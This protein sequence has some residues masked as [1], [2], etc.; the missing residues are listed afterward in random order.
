MK[1]KV[2]NVQVTAEVQVTLRIKVPDTWGGD[3]P[4]EQVFRQARDSAVSILNR[5]LQSE[6]DQH[7]ISIV[8]TPE[9]KTIIGVRK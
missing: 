1:E 2:S 4:T 8:A 7:R 9:I 5:A 6:R 3:C